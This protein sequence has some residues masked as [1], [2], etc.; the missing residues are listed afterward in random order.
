M[1]IEHGRILITVHLY[2]TLVWQI[3]K[4]N[5]QGNHWK[6]G[7]GIDYGTVHISGGRKG[8]VSKTWPKKCQHYQHKIM[9]LALCS[10]DEVNQS[11]SVREGLGSS[12]LG[13]IGEKSKREGCFCKGSWWHPHGLN[14]AQQCSNTP[15]TQNPSQNLVMLNNYTFSLNEWQRVMH[16]V[17]ATAICQ[18]IT[19]H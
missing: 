5:S 18:H 15:R 7:R 13:M 10:F 9:T 11:D 8:K 19:T 17:K 6:H 4:G 2:T 3:C 14:A 1:D 12:S 16:W